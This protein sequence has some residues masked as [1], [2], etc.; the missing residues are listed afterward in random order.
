M[1]KVLLAGKSG[2]IGSHIYKYLI[3]KYNVFSITRSK[4]DLAPNRFF[5][6]LNNLDQVA[7]FVDTYP[8]FDSLIFLVGLAHSKG[9]NK[10]LKEFDKVNF[11]TLYNLLN[12]L[13][14]KSKVPNQIIFSS[15][16][17]VY[18]ESYKTDYYF[19][20]SIK[21]GQTPYAVTKSKAEDFLLNK[22]SD[23][24]WILRFSPVYAPN[25]ERNIYKRIK[26]GSLFFRVGDGEK[27]LSLCNVKNIVKAVNCILNNK[28]PNG[29]YNISDT[30]EY[31]YNDLLNFYKAKKV[32]KVPFLI[33]KFLLV[34]GGMLRNNFLKD[35]SLKLLSNN[36]YP[37]QKISKHIKLNSLLENDS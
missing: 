27:K 19:E 17:S 18:G 16:I 5:C 21:N 15:T 13:E 12:L 11:L 4:E 25:F 7:E 34:I 22:Y 26:I 31:T 29:I 28:V 3:D 20:D 10:E 9:K 1:K 24:S 33:I 23:K 6:D 30:K 37:S 14:K 35:N 2:I 32:A 36:L 8:K